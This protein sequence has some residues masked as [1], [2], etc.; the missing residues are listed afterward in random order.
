MSSMRNTSVNSTIR[1]D[2]VRE[3]SLVISF[4]LEVLFRHQSTREKKAHCR[5]AS[6]SSSIVTL[7]YTAVRAL[8]APVARLSLDLF[9]HCT[10]QHL[11]GHS[12]RCVGLC[13]L[14][15]G[16]GYPFCSSRNTREYRH[17]AP[18]FKPSNRLFGDVDMEHARPWL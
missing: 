4:L 14:I 17:D 16:L 5:Y 6:I 11:R 10:R 2:R 3:I 15:C 18:Q 9:V 1:H 8:V 7:K 12:G 13:M